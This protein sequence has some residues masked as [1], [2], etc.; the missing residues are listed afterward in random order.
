MRIFIQDM[1]N[2]RFRFS[3]LLHDNILCNELVS[4]RKKP[5]NIAVYKNSGGDEGIRTPDLIHAKHALSQLSYTPIF[6][7]EYNVI[8]IAQICRFVKRKLIFF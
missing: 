5:L 8:M 6:T 4:K 3:L 1:K 7:L 2:E